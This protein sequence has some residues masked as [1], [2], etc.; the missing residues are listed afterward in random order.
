MSAPLQPFSCNLTL[1]SGHAHVESAALCDYVNYHIFMLVFWGAASVCMT[2]VTLALVAYYGRNATPPQEDAIETCARWALGTMFLSLGFEGAFV[3]F[4]AFC[5]VAVCSTMLYLFYVEAQRAVVRL[6]RSATAFRVTARSSN[7]VAASPS[8]QHQ[9]VVVIAS[10]ESCPI[11]LETDA[12]PWHATPCG[13]MF[14]VDCIGR[15]RQGTCPLCRER[16]AC[17]RE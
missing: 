14:H 10:I 8:E 1:V 11:C 13:H 3:L 9:V 5:F 17:G 12:G 6:A 15:W 16:I 4:Y 7:A 2:C